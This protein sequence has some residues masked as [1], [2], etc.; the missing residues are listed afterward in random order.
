[1]KYRAHCFGKLPIYKDYV[2]FECTGTAGASFRKWMEA[3]FGRMGESVKGFPEGSYRMVY[4]REGMKETVLAV[5]RD[6]ADYE[7]LRRF[8]FALFVT[9]PTKL[10]LLDWKVCSTTASGT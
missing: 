6:S 5:L 9:L 4:A 10:L 3:G 8:P 7:N 1:M 2:T